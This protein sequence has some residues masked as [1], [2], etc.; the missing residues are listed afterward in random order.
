MGVAGALALSAC[1]GKSTG[2]GTSS[3][4]S[5]GRP[6]TIGVSLSLTGD[7]SDSGK[8]AQR[9]YE[10]WVDVVNAN[11]GIL[12]HKVALKV[13]DDIS[14]PNQVITD[15][16]NLITK[17]HVDFVF[18]PFSSLL[19]VPAAQIASR[20]GY[21]L[22][23]PAGG[24]PKVF[25]QH[26]HNLF[27]VQPAPIVAQGQVFAD[28]ILSLPESQRPKT[29]AYPALDDPF[30]TPLVDH[31]RAAFEKAG[32]RTV[33]TQTYPPETVDLTP[34]VSKV[35]AAH[36]DLVVA[37]TQSQ[38]AYAMVKAMVQLHFAPRWLYV[39]N[40]AN[41]PR[42]FPSK[43]G[44]TN[45]DGIF[46]GS[47]WFPAS[48]AFRSAEFVQAYQRKFGETANQIDP[49]SAE[50]F[51]CGVLLEEA[52]KKTGKLDN[53]TL[54]SA[55]HTGSWPS[56]EGNL[57]WDANGAPQSSYVLVQWV[58]GKLLPVFPTDRAQQGPSTSPLAW[59]QRG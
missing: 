19:T 21:A 18:G 53:A 48:T 43:V 33:Y 13:V 30:A 23:E 24:G 38:D 8:A 26:L 9:G 49:T 44:Q 20:Y 10:T 1:A 36:P 37:G 12:G 14:S 31:V 29:A 45:V 52:V 32:I 51:S 41:D 34:T 55:L 17:D 5:N 6:I 54:I 4:I 28:Y 47:D 35:A 22:L 46:S 25:A 58:G 50:A 15:Y 40:G 27:F 2:T 57:S 7:F 59:A 56:P 3:A 16:Q 39:S 42:E 11:G